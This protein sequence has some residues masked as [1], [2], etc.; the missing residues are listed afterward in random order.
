MM[1]FFLLLWSTTIAA[2]QASRRI[3]TVLEIPDDASTVKKTTWDTADK[4]LEE[5]FARALHNDWSLSYQYPPLPHHNHNHHH[6]NHHHNHHHHHDSSYYDDDYSQQPYEEEDDELVTPSEEDSTDDTTAATDDASATD[7]GVANDDV[8]TGNDDNAIVIAPTPGAA[9][10][11]SGS[12]PPPPVLVVPLETQLPTVEL[13]VPNE[14]E[15]TEP[16]VQDSRACSSHSTCSGEAGFCCP[17]FNNVFKACCFGLTYPPLDDPTDAPAPSPTDVPVPS[18]TDV[19]VPS[20][21]DVPDKPSDLPSD[22]PSSTPLATT[23]A[24]VDAVTEMVRSATI[25]SKCGMTEAERSELLIAS[26]AP[27]SDSPAFQAYQWLDFFDDKIVCPQ[28]PTLK[29]RSALATIYYS[30]NGPNWIACSAVNGPCENADRWLSRSSECDWFGVACNSSDEVSVLTLKENGLSGDLPDVIFSLTTLTGLSLD[31]NKAITGSIPPTISQL[32]LLEYIELDDNNMEG[33]IPVELYSM[34]SLKAIDMNGN[35]FS[36][37]IPDQISNLSNLMV[38]QLE[39]NEF[40]G[41]LPWFGLAM[42]KDLRTYESLPCF[43]NS[44]V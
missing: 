28:H 37:N 34:T 1:K 19:P 39:D 29:Q 11:P 25:E 20:P 5:F 35:S 16:P 3:R 17:D 36:G 4:E 42:L 8:T 41:L 7:D 12:S 27:E 14:I 33:P 43:G 2:E 44:T 6:H 38:L 15:P 10:S 23:E 22:S 24:P 18:P 9:P 21:T 31:H 30:L 40:D 13:V 26:L 32:S